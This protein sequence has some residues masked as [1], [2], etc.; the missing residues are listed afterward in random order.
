MDGPTSYGGG[1]GRELVAQRNGL[2]ALPAPRWS[3]VLGIL[4]INNTRSSAI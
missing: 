2:M 3:D 4:S 1:G